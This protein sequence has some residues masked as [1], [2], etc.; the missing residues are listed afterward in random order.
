MKTI[1]TIIAIISIVSLLFVIVVIINSHFANKWMD[2]CL[3]DRKAA[4]KKG[5]N[6]FWKFI[7]KI[8]F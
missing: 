1:E 8:N 7:R 3:H 4:W 5:E 2:M 6:G